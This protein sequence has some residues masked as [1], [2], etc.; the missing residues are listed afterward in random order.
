MRVVIQRVNHA[1]VDIDG[2]TVG[3]I[4][5]G[6]LLLVGIKNGDD[7]SVIKKAADKIAKM[8]IFEDEEGKTNL[9]LKDVNGEILS[10]SQFTLMANTKKGNRP[11]FV[12]A[13][14]PPM[15]KELWEDFNKELE[16]D[17]FHVETGEFG[18]DMKVS[19]EN[20]GPF[21][22]VLDL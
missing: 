1:Q 18:A 21:T 15:S 9:S 19:L 22:I 13:M 7:L 2:K 20:D 3:N 17:G 16:N 4:G 6:F 10:V 5:K 8:R 12:E 14:R 11:S